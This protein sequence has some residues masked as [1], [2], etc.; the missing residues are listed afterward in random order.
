[1]EMLTTAAKQKQNRSRPRR[2]ADPPCPCV[3]VEPGERVV[4][5]LRARRDD[6]TGFGYEAVAEV[7]VFD[8]VL[9]T[10]EPVVYVR[11]GQPGRRYV[12]VYG[13]P[14]GPAHHDRRIE[15]D[16]HLVVRP[17][18]RA[19]RQTVIDALRSKRIIAE[20]ETAYFW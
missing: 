17:I 9:G 5:G 19:D 6:K 12:L 15:P 3:T 1:M 4:Y 10:D 7:K 16:G 20:T 11:A 13:R 18:A 2:S 14:V 8:P